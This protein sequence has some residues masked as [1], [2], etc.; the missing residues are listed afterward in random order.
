MH[1]TEKEM[2]ITKLTAMREVSIKTI[3]RETNTR[4]SSKGVQYNSVQ[5]NL[6]INIIPFRHP[7]DEMEFSFVKEKQPGYFPLPKW[8]YPKYLWEN[9][10]EELQ[11]I[12]CL[13]SDFS[14][15]AGA[16]YK[17]SINLK[18]NWK[19]ADH[20]YTKSIFKYFL[21]KADAVRFGFVNDVEVW[22]LDNTKKNPKY[23]TYKRFSLRVQYAKVSGGMELAVSYDGTSLVHKQS[24]AD[25]RDIDPEKISKVIYNK[26]VYSYQR[27]ENQHIKLYLEDIYPIL[28]NRL[29]ESLQI[30]RPFRR[31]PNKYLP[32]WKEIT[33][34]YNTYLN[35]DEFKA[36]IPLD[37]N[38]FKQI[39]DNKILYTKSNSNELKFGKGTGIEPK[40]DFLRL[41]P[42]RPSNQPNVRLIFIYQK[43][44][45]KK[46]VSKLYNVL[47]EGLHHPQ[48]GEQFPAMLRAIKQNFV[49]EESA[50]IEF[51]SSD[52]AL[53][54]INQQLAVLEKKEN[55][56]YVALYV[57]PVRKDEK[58]H[59][60]LMLYYRV[61]ELLLRRD[62]TSQ[63]IYRE[64]LFDSS[65]RWYL[66]NI[67]IALLAK[68]NGVPWRLDTDVTTDLV[69]GVGAFYSLTQNTKYIGSTFC[70]NNDGTFQ[71]FNCHKANET[72]MLAGEISNAIMKFY[73]DNHKKAKRL[74]IHFYKKI[75]QKELQPIYD[76]LHTFNWDIPVIVVT[77]NKTISNDYVAFD[78]DS[79]NLMPK[80]G[81]ILPIGKNQYLLF[82]NTRYRTVETV[83]DNPFPIK[84]T[85]SASDEELLND[86]LMVKE[87]IDQVYQFSRMYWKSVRQQNLPVTIKY[88]EMAAEIYAFFQ[89]N[90]PPFGTKNLWFL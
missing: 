21:Q 44:D 62:I 4:T 48:Y 41:G 74:I 87:L 85:F 11:D 39:K 61:K 64:S 52:T 50:G 26:E 23:N 76:V 17:V 71:G 19:F 51:E 82:N 54:E 27:E 28:S 59:E 16:D 81:T 25:L 31:I 20:Y 40:K 53:A 47:R 35:N 45:K 32:Y 60:R 86:L 3:P 68:I 69:V 10:E 78:L 46:Y 88:P 7:V 5:Q 43:S 24:L 65:F 66:P 18:D 79:E 84:L 15:Q 6:R 49:L 67:A 22:L 72:D 36:L 63:V 9:Y 73:V 90:V 30:D 1:E 37:P 56:Q 34:F 33:T 58:D 29:L 14:N 57:S 83:K 80:S 2:A 38:G 55:T 77:I 12:D 70:F 8:A 75:S 89:D 13:Y 42:Y